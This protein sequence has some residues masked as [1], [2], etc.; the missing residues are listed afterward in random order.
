L[1]VKPFLL[2][3][4]N[5]VWNTKPLASLPESPRGAVGKYQE[6]NKTNSHLLTFVKPHGSYWQ[7][8]VLRPFFTE[9][10]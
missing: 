6:T 3:G 2:R 8:R 1:E 5:Q 4:T 9:A 10:T 7:K